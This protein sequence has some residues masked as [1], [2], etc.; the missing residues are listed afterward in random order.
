MVEVSDVS[1]AFARLGCYLAQSA[2]PLWE[3]TADIW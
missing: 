2:A 1:A 3:R